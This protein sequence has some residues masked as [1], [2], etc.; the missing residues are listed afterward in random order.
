MRWLQKLGVHAALLLYTLVAISPVLLI[1]MNSFKSRRAI[2]TNPLSF[3]TAET[4]DPVGYETVFERSTFHVYFGNSL[5][6]TVVSLL[7]IL[8]Q[9][10]SS[11]ACDVIVTR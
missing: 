4:F 3:P 10:R 6:V 7:L 9:T 1:I 11:S 2:F 8:S 5:I